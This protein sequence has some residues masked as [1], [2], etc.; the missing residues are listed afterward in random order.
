[1]QSREVVNRA[2]GIAI[3]DN[4]DSA[5]EIRV[6]R[7]NGAQDPVAQLRARPTRIEQRM[8]DKGVVTFSSTMPVGVLAS[9]EQVPVAPTRID[10]RERSACMERM[11]VPLRPVPTIDIE[12]GSRILRLSSDAGTF[13]WTAQGRWGGRI[14]RTPVF[15]IDSALTPFELERADSVQVTAYDANA[16][17]FNV[18][19]F[20][21]QA[22]VRGGLGVMG[23]I[24]SSRT[25]SLPLK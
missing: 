10:A 13:L 5:S 25:A 9:K 22:G 23:A 24:V 11:C 14:L 15:N 7:T 1:M 6:R 19:P 12:N 2:A 3:T 17:A 4:R 18:P 21:D 8:N 20:R 16:A